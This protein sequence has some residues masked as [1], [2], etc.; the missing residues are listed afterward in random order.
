MEIGEEEPAIW[1]EPIE[2]RELPTAEPLPDELPLE[3]PF[4]PTSPEEVPA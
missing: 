1:V 4:V 3:S 2:P